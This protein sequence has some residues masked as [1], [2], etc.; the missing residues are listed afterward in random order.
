[1]ALE[2]AARAAYLLGRGREAAQTYESLLRLAPD[3]GDVWK[4]LG[5][6]YREVLGDPAEADRCFRRA[7]QLERDPAERAALEALLR[8]R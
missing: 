6:L 8:D 2:N 1:V 5:A 7:L 3:R 4:A